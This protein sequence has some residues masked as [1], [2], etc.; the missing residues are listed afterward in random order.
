V[1]EGETP[2]R[3]PAR[4]RRYVTALL[5]AL[6]ALGFTFYLVL[7]VSLGLVLL[8]TGRTDTAPEQSAA[9][10]FVALMVSGGAAAVTFVLFYRRS[11]K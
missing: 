7:S 4:R 8:R 10:R 5:M 3:Q 9:F 11:K 6:M 2:S 1:S